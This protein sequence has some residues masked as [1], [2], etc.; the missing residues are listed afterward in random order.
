MSSSGVEQ[1]RQG[2]SA[3]FH[4][5]ASLWRRDG[6]A[7]FSSNL[8]HPTWLGA[9]SLEL[10]ADYSSLV[11]R[12]VLDS[13]ADPANYVRRATRGYAFAFVEARKSAFSLFEGADPT[14]LGL[15][16]R[17]VAEQALARAE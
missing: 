11:M 8:P 13:F 9:S 3:W 15:L 12:W 1:L 5:G 7:R 10:A 4:D 14:E 2:A 6:L 16:A 17:V